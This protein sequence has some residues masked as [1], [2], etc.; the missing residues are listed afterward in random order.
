[1]TLQ[2]GIVGFGKIARDEHVPAIAATPGLDLVA[3]ATLEGAADGL[4]TYRSLD[5]MLAA[6]PGIG[7]V[8]MCQP[9]AARFAAARDALRAGR[10]VFLEKPPGATLA[11]V[12]LLSDLARAGGRTLFAGW[13]SRFAPSVAALRERLAGRQV[14]HVRIDWKEDV[15]IWHPGQAWIWQ[16]G[17]FGV[18]DPGINA[19]SILTHVLPGGMRLLD[20]L[21]EIPA[22]RATPIAARLDLE[23]LAG[24]PVTV[25]LDWRQD[26]PEIWRIVFDTDAGEVVFAQGGEPGETA[27][28]PIAAEYR[29]MYARFAG[30]VAGGDSDV[31]ITPLQIVADAFLRGRIAT[32]APFED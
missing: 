25:E 27:E 7:A 3:V 8:A 20:A 26:G 12:A 11:E 31:D 29:A 21:L 22:N 5:A 2:L 15:R 4:P 9:P 13:H 16:P 19:L 14:R 23:S 17:G 24:V 18:M 30:L 6:H 10:H 28:S 1:M 32:T